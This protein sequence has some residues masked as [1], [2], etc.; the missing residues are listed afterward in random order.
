MLTNPKA[1]NYEVLIKKQ[2]NEVLSN[3]GSATK[4][5]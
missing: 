4:L 3:N 5:A 2:I 1:I